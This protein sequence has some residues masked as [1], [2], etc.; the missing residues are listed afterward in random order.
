VKAELI[1]DRLRRLRDQHGMTQGDVAQLWGCSD[2]NVNHVEMRRQL[3]TTPQL[4]S[5]A[6]QINSSLDALLAGA[7]LEAPDK[8]NH[9][10]KKRRGTRKVG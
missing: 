2:V 1:G 3:P 9:H 4:L 6:A 5:F 8:L 7:V 10:V